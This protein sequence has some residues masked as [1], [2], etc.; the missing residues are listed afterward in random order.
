MAFSTMQATRHMAKPTSVH[1]NAVKGVLGYLRGTPHLSIVYERDSSFDLVG[2]CDIWH[3][4]HDLPGRL[5]CTFFKPAT[6]DYGSKYDGIGAN[7]YEHK[8]QAGTIPVRN[9]RRAGVDDF[10]SF[11]KSSDNRGALHFSA[12]GN[13]SNRSEHIAIRSD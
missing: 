9:P 8:L 13:C 11:R 10:R 1:M 4:V 3:G 6:K 7:R 2:Y 12:N 5:A